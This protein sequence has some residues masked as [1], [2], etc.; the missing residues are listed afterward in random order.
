MP[1]C[2]WTVLLLP[3]FSVALVLCHNTQTATLFYY[4]YFHVLPPTP[5]KKKKNERK[6][7]LSLGSRSQ[8]SYNQNM[9]VSLQLIRTA[10]HFANKLNLVVHDYQQKCC[11]K[12]ALLCSG[13]RSQ[14]RFSTS[15]NP[16]CLADIF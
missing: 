5:P 12:F 16:E 1:C 15:L 3:Y 9:S 2:A 4:F 13:S 7:L 8:G 6:G 14:Q 10:D 11:E